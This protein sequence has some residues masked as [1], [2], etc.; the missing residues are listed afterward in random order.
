MT[1][2]Q[3]RANVSVSYTDETSVDRL[4]DVIGVS[5]VVSRH[6]TKVFDDQFPLFDSVLTG[7]IVPRSYGDTFG[8]TDAAALALTKE[9]TADALS[10]T[11]LAALHTAKGMVESL[12][13]PDQATLAVGKTI[14]ESFAL[15][16]VYAM[17]FTLA[18]GETITLSDSSSLSIGLNKADALPGFTDLADVV[19]GTFFFH[20]FGTSDAFTLTPELGISD[21]IVLD[22]N[23]QIEFGQGRNF[24]ESQGFAVQFTFDSTKSLTE[25][26]ALAETGS[27]RMQDYFAEDYSAEDY[28][29]A[30][31]R[32]W[33]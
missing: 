17:S 15:T 14:N 5:D 1:S 24:S 25:A 28:V 29:V 27:L 7:F 11:D 31:T 21:S 6:L 32:F 10:T 13:L 9:T 23:A 4:L 2:F 26:I 3:T 12:T 22:D 30:T 20:T 16:D 33:P 8:Y 19:P 18:T